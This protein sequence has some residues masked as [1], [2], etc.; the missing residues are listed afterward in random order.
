MIE[1]RKAEFPENSITSS[2][3][4]SLLINPST[5]Q[6]NIRSESHAKTVIVGN[7]AIGSLHF[8]NRTRSASLS[9]LE[10]LE[11][12]DSDGASNNNSAK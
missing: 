3:N 2:I 1:S 12:G 7:V 6:S 11:L 10:L 4:L 5:L 8:L 9:I